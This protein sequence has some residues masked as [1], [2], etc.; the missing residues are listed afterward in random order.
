MNDFRFGLGDEPYKDR[1]AEEDPGLETVVAGRGPLAL[2]A[3]GAA[4]AGRR[5]PAGARRRIVRRAG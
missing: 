3:S 1:F 4:A 5:L 2:L